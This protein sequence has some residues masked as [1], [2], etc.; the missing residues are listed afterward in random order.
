[1]TESAAPLGELTI[2]GEVATLTYHRRLPYPIAHVWAAIT[3]PG[4]RAAWFGETTIEPRAGG[5]ITM[6]P[7]DPPAAAD[8]K[9]MTGRILVWDP[10][11]V[12][13]HEWHQ[14]I[15]GDGVVRY[16]LSEDGAATLL[17]FTHRGLSVSNAKGFA[18]G[19]HAFLDRLDAHLAGRPLPGWSERYTELAPSYPPMHDTV[20]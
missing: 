2:N 11:H 15:I 5:A 7:D 18:P 20:G 16:E 9:R 19:E 4:Q 6:L 13:E 17:T 14:R 8:A 12:F 3:D 10:P 1:M